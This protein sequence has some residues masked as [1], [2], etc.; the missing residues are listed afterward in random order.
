MKFYVTK[1]QKKDYTYACL[2]FNNGVREVVVTFDRYVI[3][4]VLN[5]SPQTLEAMKVGD[6][7]AIKY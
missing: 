4:T 1:K 2:V 6:K 3:M 7:I 5:C